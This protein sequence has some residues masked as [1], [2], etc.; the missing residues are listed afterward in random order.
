MVKRRKFIIGLGAL[1][2][3]TVA[4]TGTGAFSQATASD[5]S[6]QVE[7]TTDDSAYLGLLDSDSDLENDQYAHQDEDG[8]LE[9]RFD[10]DAGSSGFAGS[11]EGLGPDSVYYFDSVFGVS[12]LSDNEDIQPEVE[13]EPQNDGS[14]A[15]FGIYSGPS[16]GRDS[17]DPDDLKEANTAG[18][19][20][21]PP[22]SWKG[23]GVV[24]NTEGLSDGA[25]IRGTLTVTAGE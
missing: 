23:V 1:S 22:G 12:N 25:T 14:D 4:A 5:R 13:F 17:V 19:G 24:I 18:P 9:L 11:G 16:G 7:V 15:A 10:G 6:V 2:A 3:G 21:L 8:K 20:G